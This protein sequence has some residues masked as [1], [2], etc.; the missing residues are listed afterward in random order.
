MRNVRA[1]DDAL[2]EEGEAADEPISL[3]IYRFSKRGE[4]RY[5]I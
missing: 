3:E 2:S 5:P 4:K 1:M